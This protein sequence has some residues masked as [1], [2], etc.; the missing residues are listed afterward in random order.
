MLIA[1]REVE[2]PSNYKDKVECR[3]CVVCLLTP[4]S[5]KIILPTM[6][7]YGYPLVDYGTS[8]VNSPLCFKDNPPPC[9][10][11]IFLSQEAERDSV[12]SYLFE[13]EKSN[14]LMQGPCG[15]SYFL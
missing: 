6:V 11:H 7:I 2:G 15:K 9:N 12:F 4:I 10:L 5:T 3:E 13:T 8:F 14:G 1:W